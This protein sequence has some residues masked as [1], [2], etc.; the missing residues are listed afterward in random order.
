MT[1]KFTVEQ[2]AAALDR[3]LKSQERVAE[4]V[5]ADNPD[6]PYA[7]LMVRDDI[8]LL[9]AYAARLRED[10]ENAKD[11]ARYR[12]LR[13]S[14]GAGGRIYCAMD[15]FE[16][17]GQCIATLLSGKQLDEAIDAAMR[18]QGEG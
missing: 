4:Q 16:A 14:D 15:Q 1:D 7:S 5:D 8:D 2:V 17:D 6:D 13:D 11:A 12:W 10:D 9:R 18:E 3:C